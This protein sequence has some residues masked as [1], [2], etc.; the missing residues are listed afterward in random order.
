MFNKE[1]Q[2]MGSHAMKTSDLATCKSLKPVFPK[3]QCASW[4]M[5]SWG[6]GKM[7]TLT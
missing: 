1:T 4:E 6:Y 5:R 7:Q 3:L 2:V